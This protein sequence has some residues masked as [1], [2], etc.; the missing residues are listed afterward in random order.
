[1]TRKELTAKAFA[2]IREDLGNEVKEK[3]IWK[4]LAE[5]TDNEVYF[6]VAYP[7]ERQR[8]LRKVGDK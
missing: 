6:F 4:A 2:M 3:D 5:T 7:Q 8:L 1:M